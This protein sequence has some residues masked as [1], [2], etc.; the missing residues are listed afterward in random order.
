MSGLLADFNGRFEAA[1]GYPPGENRLVAA[2]PEA[3]RA[4]A[5]ALAAAGAPAELVEFYGR[6]AELAMPDVA[7]GFF[8]HPVE[9]V[10][11][12]AQPTRLTGAAEDAITVFGSDGGGGLLAFG[13]AK[14][15]IYHLAGGAL[16]GS[17]YE[18]SPN[19]FTVLSPDLSGLLARLLAELIDALP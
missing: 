13:A 3:G 4:A 10:L 8:I 11:D 1:F 12:G 2:S 7:N 16:V 9:D 6:V 17:T 18:V 15:E 19:G 5:E 14:G